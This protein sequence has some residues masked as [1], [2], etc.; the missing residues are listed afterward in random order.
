[1]VQRK[2]LHTRQITID[3]YERDDD[4]YDLEATLVDYKHYDFTRSNGSVRKA[5]EPVHDLLLCIT[6]DMSGLIVDAKVSYLAAPYAKVCPQIEAAYA[7]F[8]GLH[9]LR[10]FR[11]K[12]REKFAKT[13][14]CTHMNELSTLL[15]T[16]FVQSRSN[17]RITQAVESGRRPFQLEGCH[18]YALDS[19]VVEEFYPQWYEDNKDKESAQGQGSKTEQSSN[20]TES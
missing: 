5:G 14:G 8:I 7:G 15:P 3:A 2:Q 12:V 4:C 1:M 18:A 9:L 11:H 13:A 10:G 20:D 6:T 17:K 16:V 19:P